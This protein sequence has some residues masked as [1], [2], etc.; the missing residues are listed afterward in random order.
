MDNNLQDYNPDRSE[1]LHGL[2]KKS[3]ERTSMLRELTANHPLRVIMV[4]IVVGPSGKHY[5]H[6]GAAGKMV[7]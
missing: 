2:E 1:R 6:G 3:R 5:D 7:R 4:V